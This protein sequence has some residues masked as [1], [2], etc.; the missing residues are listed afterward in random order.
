MKTYHVRFNY[1][2][3]LTYERFTSGSDVVASNITAAI[4]KAILKSEGFN[5]E[6]CQPTGASVQ[7]GNGPAKFVNLA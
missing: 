7:S 1:E 6:T 2:E 5:P 3:I 4:V